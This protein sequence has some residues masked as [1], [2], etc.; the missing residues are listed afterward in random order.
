MSLLFNIFKEAAKNMVNV[1]IIK[2]FV[3]SIRKSF[4]TFFGHSPQI[5][6][7]RLIPAEQIKCEYDF[8]SDISAVIALPGSVIG[9]LAIAFK[10][11]TAIKLSAEL[12]GED[13]SNINEDVKDVIGELAN[14]VAGNIKEDLDSY[15]FEN[16]LPNIYTGTDKKI[17]LPKEFKCFSVDFKSDFGPFTMRV[18]VL[19]DV[20]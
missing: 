10:K 16:A 15:N 5:D 1:E 20:N 14:T 9:S 17:E 8:F 2:P 18:S 7:P 13:I 3:K 12:M 19:D 4:E 11:D 6:D